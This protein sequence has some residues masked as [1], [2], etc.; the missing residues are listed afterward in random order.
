MRHSFVEHYVCVSRTIPAR[1]TQKPSKMKQ[2]PFHTQALIAGLHLIVHI[3]P[4][5]APFSLA[6]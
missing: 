5:M 4:V 3:Q 1:Q 6:L 2:N